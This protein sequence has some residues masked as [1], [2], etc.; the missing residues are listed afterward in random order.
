[1]Q[2]LRHVLQHTKNSIPGE[3]T[4]FADMVKNLLSN[5]QETLL[6]IYNGIWEANVLSLSLKKSV[7]API[8]KPGKTQ[9]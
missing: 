4:I 3:D 8:A 5:S 1:M 7:I 6:K 2:K 9:S